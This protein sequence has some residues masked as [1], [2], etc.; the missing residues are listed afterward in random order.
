MKEKI[1]RKIEKIVD[2]IISKPENE[3]TR[4]DYEIIASEVRDIRFRE[5]EEERQSKLE[6][7]LAVANP[8]FTGFGKGKISE[9]HPAD[10]AYGGGV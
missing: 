1:E 5:A 2:Y 4:D 3:I 6:H 9:I 8:A 7:M 10:C